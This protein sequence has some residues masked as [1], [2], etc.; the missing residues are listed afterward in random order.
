MDA[1][2]ILLIG[3]SG[4]NNTA[5]G[6]LAPGLANGERFGGSAGPDSPVI[7]DDGNG[8]FRVQLV[9]NTGTALSPTYLSRAYYYGD[10][11]LWPK[12]WSYN[13]HITNAHWIFPGDRIRL[14]DPYESV[15]GGGP[16][17]E[18]LS[19]AETYDPRDEG[20]QTYLLERYAFID[21]E[22]AD[23]ARERVADGSW[24]RRGALERAR[25]E[26]VRVIGWEHEALAATCP[27]II[28]YVVPGQ[29][30]GNAELLTKHECGVT[31]KTPEE[32]GEQAKRLLAD[33]RA[34]AKR[35]KA[36]MRAHSVPDAAMRIARQVLAHA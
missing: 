17:G 9:S 12:I 21:E 29:E 27:A 25:A 22:V 6:D 33:D 5:N 2:R 8:L 34:E 36:N 15:S 14:T 31:T 1:P 26:V 13:P 35:M 3:Y 30:E 18:G 16:E 32:S 19:F 7:S 20:G 28:D 11:Y 4:A 10:M 24:S 23:Y